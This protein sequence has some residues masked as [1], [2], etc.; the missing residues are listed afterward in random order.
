MTV[1][2]FFSDKHEMS[3]LSNEKESWNAYSAPESKAVWFEKTL[4]LLPVVSCWCSLTRWDSSLFYL[5]ILTTSFLGAFLKSALMPW[6]WYLLRLIFHFSYRGRVATPAG[7][8][9]FLWATQKG[10]RPFIGSRGNWKSSKKTFKKSRSP[11]LSQ[12]WGML[13]WAFWSNCPERPCGLVV[14][15]RF[16]S[17]S[18]ACCSMGQ[19]DR[20]L[21]SRKVDGSGRMILSIYFKGSTSE[22][23]SKNCYYQTS[24][25]TT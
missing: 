4:I 9:S 18:C 13:T 25:T 7:R 1:S 5:G 23:P 20:P 10:G 21:P 22:C 3:A 24:S 17:L 19:P 16:P 6:V 11:S 2:L 15:N 8:D 12:C 14:T